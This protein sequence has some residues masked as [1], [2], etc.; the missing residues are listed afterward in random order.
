MLVVQEWGVESTPMVWIS[1]S[2]AP[3]EGSVSH[4]M[5]TQHCLE[6]FLLPRVGLG[7]GCCWMQVGRGQRC[8]EAPYHAQNSPPATKNDPR[9]DNWATQ[10]SPETWISDWGLS[11]KTLE[12]L[13]K[14][15]F[16]QPADLKKQVQE[17]ECQC[18]SFQRNAYPPD[19]KISVEGLIKSQNINSILLDS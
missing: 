9:E 12:I 3:T 14:L 18:Q 11:W 19:S 1:R 15:M 7:E 6:T 5:D 8:Y 13:P 2:M 10:V 17:T 16:F 4:P